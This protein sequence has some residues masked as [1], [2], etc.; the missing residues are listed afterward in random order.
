LRE[1]N[2]KISIIISIGLFLFAAILAMTDDAFTPPPAGFIVPSIGDDESE[3]PSKDIF[4]PYDEVMEIPEWFKGLVWYRSN[5]GG[6]ALEEAS[7]QFTALRNEYAL[8]IN[9]A[10]EEELPEELIEFYDRKYFIEIRTLYEKGE[11]IR[12][13]WIFRDND[14]RA[15]L[16]AVFLERDKGEEV[17]YEESE[18]GEEPVEI[19]VRLSQTYGFIEIYDETSLLKTE[20]QYSDDGGK[21]KT[22]FR[23]NEK[24][25]LTCTVSVWEKNEDD[26]GSYAPS[27]ADLFR[28]NRSSF[29]RGVERVFYKDRRL[30]L[31][32]TIRV[33]F[34]YLIMDA[35]KDSF[36]I[37]ERLHAYPDF[38]GPMEVSQDNKIVYS[39][40]ERGRIFKQTLFDSEDN[41]IWVIENTWQNERI[42]SISRKDE[43]EELSAEFEYNSAG[44]RILERNYRDGKLERIVRSEGKTDIVELYYENVLVLRAVWEEGRK[45]S[46]TRT[47]E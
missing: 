25:L 43:K 44:D 45:I 39:A 2:K 46:E 19:R 40:D 13:Q 27:Y 20:Y 15:R 41:V 11:Q 1:L 10:L 6:M 30:S 31:A 47:F 17:R 9:F 14:G 21:T 8:A 23:Y 29:L 28:Y 34:P 36:F 24:L 37:S 22:D 3:E 42:I 4:L 33:S 32:D 5:K 7:S 26:S 35:A 12:A 38:F 18:E 16:V